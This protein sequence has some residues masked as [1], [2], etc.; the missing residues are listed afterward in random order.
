M[1]AHKNSEHHKSTY[2]ID[3]GYFK[4]SKGNEYQLGIT[5]ASYRRIHGH[6][7]DYTIHGESGG[8]YTSGTMDRFFIHKIGKDEMFEFKKELYKRAFILGLLKKERINVSWHDEQGMGVTVYPGKEYMTKEEY[9][10]Y[11][12]S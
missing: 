5:D 7:C 6:T 11:I 9:Y 12:M 2:R 10:N 1:L 8:D 4:D 3:L